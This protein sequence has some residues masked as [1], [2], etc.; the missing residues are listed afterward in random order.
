MVALAHEAK[1]APALKLALVF[2]LGC[3]MG[4]AAYL[5]R[6]YFMPGWTFPGMRILALELIPLFAAPAALISGAGFA[7]GLR[8][9]GLRRRRLVHRSPARVAFLMGLAYLP[10]IFAGFLWLKLFTL[11]SPILPLIIAGGGGI[12]VAGFWVGLCTRPG[13]E[14]G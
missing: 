13:K 8:F 9:F 2:S 6:D 12:L 10:G 11:P 7:L 4:G 1:G 5:V 3:L 14:G